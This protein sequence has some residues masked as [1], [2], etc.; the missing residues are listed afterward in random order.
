[1]N[2]KDYLLKKLPE[3][4]YVKLTNDLKAIASNK[5]LIHSITNYVAMNFSA[6][7][8]LSIGAAPVMSRAPQEVAEMAS[9]ASAVIL[10]LGTL[11]ES[12]SEAI[13]LAGKAANSKKIPVIYDPVAVGATTFRRDFN[14]KFLKS[15]HVDVIRANASEVLAL[16]NTHL[17]TK[18]V[19]SKDKSSDAVEIAKI[20]AKQLKA[21]VI[22]S[23]KTDYVT[24]GVNI[25]ELCFGDPLMSKVTA[26]GCSASGIV[27]AFCAVNK[28][29][30]TASCNSMALCG[31]A[32]ELAAS[33]SCGNGSMMINFLDSLMS[34]S[35]F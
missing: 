10:N 18:G 22:I 20:L 24:D 8:L 27:G 5:P 1:M 29:Y 11:E 7:S 17:I 21:V 6:N 35:S 4:D 19:D 13:L 9:Y 12:S 30:F 31:L 28:D 15:V 34:L 14:N 3:T 26:M 16:G 25:K 23:G 33:K 2:T 32:G